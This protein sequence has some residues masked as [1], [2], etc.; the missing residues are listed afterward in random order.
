MANTAGSKT[1]K[2]TKIATS[3]TK[4]SSK[5]CNHVFTRGPKEG[6]KCGKSCIE[7]YCNNH[8]PAKKTYQKS[9]YR[10]KAEN[11]KKKNQD[12]RIQHI[13]NVSID[14]LPDL[15][16]LNKKIMK[17]REDRMYNIKKLIGVNI[18]LG[19]NQDDVIHKIETSYFGECTCKKMKER[20]ITDELV[21]IAKK[22]DEDIDNWCKDDKDVK[23]AVLSSLRCLQCGL[24]SLDMCR[25]CNRSFRKIYFVYDG[26][27][28]KVA[29]LKV[30]KLKI[31][32][33]RL[34]NKI[35]SQ[36][37]IRQAIMKRLSEVD[38]N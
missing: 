8:K 4:R 12:E 31:K 24:H 33:E 9:W 30:K 10:N 37:L 35:R 2:T 32:I 23:S 21:K 5:K 38:E 16:T 13:N 15:N 27:N 18:F 19:I 26:S 28:E 3:K 25:Y 36:I 1:S 20:D 6:Q 22:R 17:Y 11:E 29:Q 34:E 14:K 7:Y